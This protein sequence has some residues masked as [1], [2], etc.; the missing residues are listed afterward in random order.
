MG[1]MADYYGGPEPEVEE[2]DADDE[3]YWVTS[4]KRRILIET[5]S[6]THLKNTI[7][8]L[9][10]R[11]MASLVN[12][13]YGMSTNAVEMAEAEMSTLSELTVAR[14][15]RMVSELEERKKDAERKKNDAAGAEAPRG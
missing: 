3:L 9:D 4:D 8:Y 15:R 1:D 11:G 7:A 14:Y 12:V 5:M 10:R 6:D 2:L 13:R